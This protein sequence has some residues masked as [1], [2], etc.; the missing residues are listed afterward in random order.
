MKKI[1]KLMMVAAALYAVGCVQPENVEFASDCDEITIDAVGG[2]H[3]LRISSSDS[4]IAS[5][6][7]TW[8]TISPANGR[9]SAECRIQ[10]D[11]ALH[12]NARHG[13]VLIQN[14]QTHEERTITINQEG[15][16][17]AIDIEESEIS[18]ANYKPYNERKFS[19][20]LNTNVDFEVEIPSNA[21]WLSHKQYEVNLNR[22]I[23]PREVKV[24]FEWDINTIPEERVAEVK[25]VPKGGETLARQDV[26]KVVQESADPIEENTRKGDSVALVG[27]QRSLQTLSSWDVSLPME[28]WTGVV[29]WSERHNGYTPEKK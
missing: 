21:R 12:N 3:K 2:S 1:Y 4:W 16:P 14:L 7:N 25:F 27:I 9:G 6:D 5:T 18:I 28:R 26:L 24:E 23:R 22:G 10:I 8:I 15:F 19:V 11:S 29:L 17:Y 20:T 13:E